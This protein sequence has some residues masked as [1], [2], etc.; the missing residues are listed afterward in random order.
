MIN[1]VFFITSVE[2]YYTGEIILE[3]GNFISD[4]L[5]IAWTKEILSIVYGNSIWTKPLFEVKGY[6]IVPSDVFWYILVACS[7]W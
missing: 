6:K 4:G 7:S 3:I 5:L 1:M 2:Q